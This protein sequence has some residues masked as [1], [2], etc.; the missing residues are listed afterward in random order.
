MENLDQFVTR[1]AS[2]GFTE[3]EIVDEALALPEV[4]AWVGSDA[5]RANVVAGAVRATWPGFPSTLREEKVAAPKLV[6]VLAR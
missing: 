6:P 1:L 4:A 3:D 5:R 2:V